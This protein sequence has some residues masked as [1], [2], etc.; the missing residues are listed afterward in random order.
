MKK[1]SSRWIETPLSPSA[2]SLSVMFHYLINYILGN[3][4]F[5]NGESP[6]LVK[7]V[8]VH[9]TATGYAQSEEED[10]GGIDLSIKDFTFSDS[11]RHD[12]GI[13]LNTILLPIS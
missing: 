11:V 13:E 8:I 3:T 12:W 6:L 2:E 5:S 4:L 10:L 7:S 1:H 9:E